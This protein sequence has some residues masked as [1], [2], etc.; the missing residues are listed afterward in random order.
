MTFPTAVFSIVTLHS[1][2]LITGNTRT[3][4]NVIQFVRVCL[5]VIIMFLTSHEVA[6]GTF[7]LNISLFFA[8]FANM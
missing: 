4:L 2:G 3:I 8:Y 1:Y 7:V 6:E 5:S